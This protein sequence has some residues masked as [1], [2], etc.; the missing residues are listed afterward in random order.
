MNSC[1]CASTPTVTRI[2]TSCTTPAAPAIASSRSIS[3]SSRTRRGRRR[4]PPRRSARRPTCCCRAA[5]FARPGSRRAARRP[6][7]RRCRRPA[8]ALLGDPARHLACTGTPWPRTGRSAPPKAWR[9]PGSAPGSRPRRG[10]TRG[11]GSCGPARSTGDPGQVRARRRSPRRPSA[12]RRVGEGASR[13]S[14]G[15]RRPPAAGRVMDFL[16]V[17]GTSRVRPHIRSGALARPG[18]RSPLRQHLPR[19]RAHSPQPRSGQR[20]GL[21]VAARQD[22]AG[23]VEP[24]VGACQLLQVPGHPMRRAQPRRRRSSTRGKSHRS[25]RSRLAFP[26]R[27]RAAR[28]RRRRPPPASSPRSAALRSHRR[29]A[30]RARTARSRPGC[31]CSAG[32]R[33][34]RSRSIGGSIERGPG[35]SGRVDADRL[36]QVLQRS[37]DGAGAIAHPDRLAVADQVD[38][39]ADQHLDGARGRR[40]ARPR[41]PCSRPT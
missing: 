19:S 41:W 2:S 14:S 34:S 35:R 11:A 17:Q 18:L 29:R 28:R 23:V 16:G 38:H 20:R 25:P 13:A 22:A 40:R 10:R 37:H 24:V 30:G 15:A 7:R 9:T 26:G 21:L 39:L 6:A 4:P 36:D 12:A 5:R 3:S 1:V 27:G 33:A 8:Q 32:A 31:R